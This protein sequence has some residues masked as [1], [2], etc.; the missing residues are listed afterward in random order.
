MQWKRVREFLQVFFNIGDCQTTTP[1]HHGTP[2]QRMA[3]AEWAHDLANDSQKQGLILSSQEFT[4][5]F[6]AALPQILNH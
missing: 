2:N 1:G 3:A 5:L 4:A 6:E